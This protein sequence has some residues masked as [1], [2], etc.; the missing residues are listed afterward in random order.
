VNP[1]VKE[2]WVNALLS[3]EYEQGRERLVTEFPGAKDKYCCLGVLCELAPKGLAER[4]QAL[5]YIGQDFIGG[6][7]I[8]GTFPPDPV[9]EWAGIEFDIQ[10]KLAELNDGDA[11]KD[12]PVAPHSF[13]EIAQYIQDNL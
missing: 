6:T 8:C 9:A 5:G 13:A 3:G 10:E 2:L 7:S 4:A 1:E 11:D 12:V